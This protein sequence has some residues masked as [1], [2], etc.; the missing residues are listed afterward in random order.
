MLYLIGLGLSDG[1]VSLKALDAMKKCD[2]IY[3]ELYTSHWMGDLNKLSKTI[4]KKIDV[5]ERGKVESEFLIT[6]AKNKNVALLIPGDPLTATTH[7]QLIMDAKKN[8]VQTEIIHASSIY[9]VIAESG[10][11]L[12]KFGRATTLAMPQQNYF[13][14]SPYDVIAENRKMGLHTLVLLDI[15]T[16][17]RKGIEVLLELE[18]R[19]K[20]GII[21]DDMIAC[22]RLGSTQKVI[23]CGNADSLIKDKELDATP[24]VLLIPG[25]LHFAEEEALE[26]WKN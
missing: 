11:Q 18:D 2:A 10:L 12:Y 16:T 9:T 23:R 1:D 5:L 8:N 20:K 3:C 24:A 25:K 22:C 15:P 14:E 21:R 6:D 7:M 4:G 17:A 19:K 26:L 13:P